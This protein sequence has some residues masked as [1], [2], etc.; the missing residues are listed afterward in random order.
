MLLLAT[1]LGCPGVGP[2]GDDT[3]ADTAEDV[4]YDRTACG[5]EKRDP[6]TLSST[7]AAVGDV[8]ADLTFTDQCGESFRVWDMYAEYFLL[9]FTAAW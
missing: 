7:G 2:E 5:W 1:L 4:V 3:A 6:G 9:Y 8:L